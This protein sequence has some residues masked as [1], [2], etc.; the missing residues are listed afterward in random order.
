MIL[1]KW[2]QLL[3]RDLLFSLKWDQLMMLNGLIA[4]VVKDL[5][6]KLTYSSRVMRSVLRNEFSRW[7]NS[8]AEIYVLRQNQKVD[9]LQDR[10]TKILLYLANFMLFLLFS[11]H[12]IYLEPPYGQ[13]TQVLMPLYWTKDIFVS[14]SRW[15]P[16]EKG[17][18]IIPFLK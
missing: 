7:A 15:N 17:E 13:Y 2:R 11:L 6:I 1:V 16:G 8:F 18:G 3:L 9:N 14:S 12:S 5:V 10:C 4:A